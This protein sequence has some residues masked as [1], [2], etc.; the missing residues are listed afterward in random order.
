MTVPHQLPAEPQAPAWRRRG[1]LLLCLLVAGGLLVAALVFLAAGSDRALQEAV[2]EADAQDPG[3]RLPQLEEKRVPPPD[4]DNSAL[5]V[6]AARRLIPTNWGGSPGYTNLFQDLPPE[7]QL[8]AQQLAALK[9]EL[10]KVTKG[11]DEA[12]K[13]ADMPDGHFVI[14]W[15]PDVMSTNLSVIQDVRQVVS[16]L[17][18]DALLRAQ[19]KDPD[20]AVR[21]LQAA[22]DGGRSI[23]D[24]PMAIPQLVRIACVAVGTLNLERVLAQGEPSPAALAEFQH[25]LEEEDRHPYLLVMARGERAGSDQCMT[26]LESGNVSSAQITAV[27]GGPGNETLALY[28]RVPGEMK[29]E[30]AALLRYMNQLVES[31]K[32]PEPERKK[33]LE[34]LEASIRKQPPLVRLLAP[35]MSKMADADRRMH[36]HLRCAVV[37]LAAERYRQEHNRWPESVRALVD[38]G[39]LREAPVDPYDGARI[40]LKRVADGLV[41]YAVGPDGQDDGGNLDRKMTFPRGTD[42]GFRL[43][44][45]SKRRQPPLPPKPTEPPVPPDS[46]PGAEPAAGHPGDDGR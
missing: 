32:Q 16:V 25:L 13:L 43:W 15:T 17:Q 18:N 7:A 2:A 24:V 45:V 6:L 1:C 30:R 38:D 11:R 19:E 42:L 36:G 34:A 12:R 28:L 22:V 23:G 33:R 9:A 4:K 20:G 3:W 10:Q 29:R 35:A 14:N 46:P 5:Q 44:D 27:A 40:R 39:Y 31:A 37:L 21:S 8:N 41:I 26:W